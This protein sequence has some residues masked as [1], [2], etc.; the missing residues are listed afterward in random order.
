MGL[1]VRNTIISI[2]IRLFGEAQS[3]TTR[4]STQVIIGMSPT[5]INLVEDR[6]FITEEYYLY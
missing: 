5:L 2:R 4:A 6:E 3:K 1:K